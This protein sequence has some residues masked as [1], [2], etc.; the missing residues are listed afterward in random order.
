[1]LKT[2]FL[3]SLLFLSGCKT[4]NNAPIS[5]LFVIDTDNGVCSRRQ[6]TDKTTLSS[7]WVE[8]MEL[9]NCDGIIGLS[10]KEFRDLRT[11]M[12]GN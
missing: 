3:V 10:P 2:I 11:Y 7:K 8:D 12:K 6:I 9:H 1:M 4:L 5:E